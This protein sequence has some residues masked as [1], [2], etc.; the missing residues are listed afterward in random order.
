MHEDAAVA[1]SDL[2]EGGFTLM[3]VP[4]SP[5]PSLLYIELALSHEL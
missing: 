5:N 3:D 4:S 1:E 2:R